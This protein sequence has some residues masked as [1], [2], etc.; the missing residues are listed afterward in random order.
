MKDEDKTRQQLIAELNEWRGWLAISETKPVGDG[1]AKDALAPGTAPGDLA[2]ERDRVQ[3]IL[4]AAVECLPFE[5]FAIGKDGRYILQNAVS[6]RH[7][8]DAIGKRPEDCAPDENT[9][10]LWMDNNR[11]AFGG[12]QVER[13]VKANVGGETR[14]LYNIIT[15]IRDEGEQYGILGI[16]VD[17]TARKQAEEMLRESEERYRLLAE[18]IPHPVWRCDAEGGLIEFNRRWHEYTGQTP[19]EARGAGWMKALHPDDMA[20]TA[21]RV[22]DDVAEGE[23]YQTEY[24]L[25]RASD[26]SYRWHLARAIPR[27]D[28]NGTILGWFGSTSD[29]HDQKLAQEELE[30]R[31][32]ERTAELRTANE[33]LWQGIEERKRAEETLRQSH[34]ELQAIYDYWRTPSIASPRRR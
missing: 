3:A 13:E 9:R 17:I 26:G 14:H 21:Q 15:P 6:R 34:D 24:R 23:L 18:A 11:R 31:V 28:A 20:R 1:T 7:F 32:Q 22:R 27:R 19:E 33:Q 29:I 8:G 4:R 12:E 16:N 30:R 2:Y 5:F 10:Q 25:R